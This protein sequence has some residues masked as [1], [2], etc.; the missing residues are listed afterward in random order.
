[1]YLSKEGRVTLIKSTLSSLPTYFLSL[2]PI[3]MSVASRIDNIQRNFLWGGMGEGKK[4][5][6]MNWSQVC[7]PL[8]SSGLGIRNLR[9]FNRA[10]LGKWLWRFGMKGRLFGDKLSFLNMGVCREVGHRAQF[11][12][13]MVL[14][15]GKTSRRVGFI[16][17][18]S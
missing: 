16:S 15:F 7:Q 8:Q 2:F 14:V 9:L 18:V 11:Q 17:L 4:F 3:P 12:D 10:L 1:M 13:L 6:L 5:H